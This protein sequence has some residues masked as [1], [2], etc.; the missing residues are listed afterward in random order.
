MVWV[1][2]CATLL[3]AA[4]GCASDVDLCGGGAVCGMDGVTYADRCAAAAASIEVAA[5]GACGV[6]CEPVTCEIACPDG[7]A[8]GPDGCEV[9]SCREVRDAGAADGGM[10]TSDGGMSTPDASRPRPDGAV[11]PE[12]TEDCDSDGI[13]DSLDEPGQCGACGNVCPAPTGGTAKCEDGACGF[14]CG[15]G[16]ARCDDAAERCTQLGTLLDCTACGDACPSGAELGPHARP[17]CAPDGDGCDI[18]CEAGFGD[19]TDDLPGC[20]TDLVRDAQNCGACGS[21]CGEGQICEDATCRA[22]SYCLDASNW[23][24]RS[25]AGGCQLVCG[26]YTVTAEDGGVAVCSDGRE[27][28]TCEVDPSGAGAA[29]CRE[30]VTA[31]CAEFIEAVAVGL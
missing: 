27:S 16:W 28:T 15:E 17:V 9:C 11:C 4:G 2:L 24:L 21:E 30:A 3:G 25:D 23:V 7:F 22:A 6:D 5:I 10:N 19:C 13:C 8:I 1:G 31:C 14:D 26:P 12:G 29:L 20:E 18:A